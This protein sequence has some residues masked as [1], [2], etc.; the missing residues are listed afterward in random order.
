MKYTIL[1]LFQFFEINVLSTNNINNKLWKIGSFFMKVCEAN[2]L[3]QQ[4]PQQQ[5]TNEQ[6]FNNNNEKNQCW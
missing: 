2:F 1:R 5:Q 4:I 3:F 6:N